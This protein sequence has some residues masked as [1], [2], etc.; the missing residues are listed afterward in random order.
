LHTVSLVY[1]ELTLLAREK[2]FVQIAF[3]QANFIAHRIPADHRLRFDGYRQVPAH[4]EPCPELHLLITEET[5]AEA[6]AGVGAITLL[7][8][9]GAD[10]LLDAPPYY[11]T[12][13]LRSGRFLTAWKEASYWAREAN[14]SVWKILYPYGICHVLP[15]WLR[16][17]WEP[18]WRQGYASWTAQNDFTIPPWISTDFARRY[19]LRDRALAHYKPP[20]SKPRSLELLVSDLAARIGDSSRWYVAAPRGMFL[21]HPFLDNRLVRFTLSVHLSSDEKRPGQKPILAEAMRGILP[22]PIRCRRDKCDFN[23]VY[24]LGL[25]RNRRYL[26][27]L[28]HE[29]RLLPAGCFELDILTDCLNKAALGITGDAS[30]QDRLNITFSLIKWFQSQ[31]ECS[32]LSEPP[33]KSTN[34]A[35]TASR[36]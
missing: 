23:E 31:D 11:L 12:D 16:P 7:T 32:A 34:W 20:G 29:A 27:T 26:E 2:R 18:L 25:A 14:C 17:G 15:R 19:Q 35:L 4:Q 22:D 33:I 30:G 3:D 28:I 9:E 5:L 36:P 24:F 13:L 8:G 1:D 10:D 6:A 21:A